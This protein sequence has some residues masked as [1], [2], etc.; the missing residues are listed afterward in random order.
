MKD[1]AQGHYKILNKYYSCC[2]VVIHPQG[3]D[4]SIASMMACANV[5]ISS[6]NFHG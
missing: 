3:S 1:E 6:M 2:S 5:P 4:H